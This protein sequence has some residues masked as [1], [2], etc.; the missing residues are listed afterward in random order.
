MRVCSDGECVCVCVVMVSV[1]VS[2]YPMAVRSEG[3]KRARFSQMQLRFDGTLGFPGGI[4]DSGETPECSVT[5]EF[6]EEVGVAAGDIAFTDKDYIVTHVSDHT[7]FCLHFF[8][9]EVDLDTFVAMERKALLSKD[10]GQEVSQLL[11]PPPPPSLTHHHHLH[12]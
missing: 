10:W 3:I 2:V 7:H 9:R 1:C 4:V 11:S 5:R 12:N 6:V 8:A